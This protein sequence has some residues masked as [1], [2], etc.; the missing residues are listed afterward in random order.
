MRHLREDPGLGSWRDMGRLF[1]LMGS[2]GSA[3]PGRVD[4]GVR[5]LVIGVVLVTWCGGT[6]LDCACAGK[7]GRMNTPASLL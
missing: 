5:L 4:F 2:A 6:A 3:M 7:P 1:V